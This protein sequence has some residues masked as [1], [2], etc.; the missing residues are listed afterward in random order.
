MQFVTTCHLDGFQQYGGLLLR[1]WHHFPESCTLTWYAEGFDIDR[2]PRVEVRDVE[3]LER[4][5]AFKRKYAFY[6]SPYYLWDVV[7][8]S[9]KVFACYDAMRHGTGKMAW[10]DADIVPFADMPDGWPE[11]LLHDGD[12]IAMFR[13]KGWYS[14]CGLW[15]VDCDHPAHGEFWD[16]LVDLYE[17]GRFKE[18]GEWHDSYLMDAVVRNMERAG[19][20]AVTDLSGEHWQ[21]EHPMSK[22]PMSQW[23]DHLKGPHRKALGISPENQH[24]KAA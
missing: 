11:S 1:G 7:R 4:L 13:R 6:R 18:L 9:H 20:I 3:Q 2:T 23:L 15:V 22:H 5:Q 16:A 19:R 17:S 24:R 21:D 8:F 12:Y 10:I 14:E